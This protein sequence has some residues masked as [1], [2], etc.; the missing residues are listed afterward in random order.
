MI[1]NRALDYESFRD[2]NRKIWQP[3]RV[4]TPFFFLRRGAVA[5]H[6][7]NCLLFRAHFRVGVDLWSIFLIT[8]SSLSIMTSVQFLRRAG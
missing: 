4:Y 7:F 8:A 1:Y 5:S 2:I 3:L 6:S